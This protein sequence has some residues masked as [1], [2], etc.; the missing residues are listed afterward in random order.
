MNNTHIQQLALG[1]IIGPMA[2][3]AKRLLAK[4]QT[5]EVTSH[6]VDLLSLLPEKP[7]QSDY[8]EVLKLGLETPGCDLHL[9]LV[10]K[11]SPASLVEWNCIR[12][13]YAAE[14]KKTKSAEWMVKVA[15]GDSVR[16]SLTLKMESARNAK[17]K[18][19]IRA[20]IELHDAKMQRIKDEAIRAT[21]KEKR[22]IAFFDAKAAKLDRVKA[23]KEYIRFKSRSAK[24][25]AK[26]L[27]MLA[28][29]GANKMASHTANMRLRKMFQEMLDRIAKTKTVMLQAGANWTW[30]NKL[31]SLKQVC[32]VSPDGRVTPHVPVEQF[33]NVVAQAWLRRAGGHTVSGG[34]S[35]ELEKSSIE[36]RF[37]RTAPFD[38]FVYDDVS[39][40]DMGLIDF[41][42]R[43]WM[44]IASKPLT[45]AEQ[46]VINGA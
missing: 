12:A 22:T 45:K 42:A 38:W 20:E 21:A 40:K 16:D 23:R 43:E 34:C 44:D 29:A 32:L 14:L 9:K 25:A 7:R 27:E 5:T 24:R 13:S 28:R 17:A 33:R 3:S 35:S 36:G 41:V 37:D 19:D 18:K 1:A 2:E 31:A 10:E 8:L 4:S 46:D 39:G 6:E 11:L 26:I 15:S 30:T